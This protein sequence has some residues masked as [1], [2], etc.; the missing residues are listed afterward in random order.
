MSRDAD[1]QPYITVSYLLSKYR[2]VKMEWDAQGDQ[3][4]V[5]EARARGTKQ[6]AELEA[7]AWAKDEG[8]EYR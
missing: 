4:I 8:I 2:A 7:M 6:E 1:S 5:S 3:Y